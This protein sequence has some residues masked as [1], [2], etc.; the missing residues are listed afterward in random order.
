MPGAMESFPAVAT[1]HNHK[2]QAA[3]V[4][5][6][7]AAA[8]IMASLEK[9]YIFS[10]SGSQGQVL[11]CCSVNIE[12]FVST[13]PYPESNLTRI[14]PFSRIYNSFSCTRNCN[15]STSLTVCSVHKS[16]LTKAAKGTICS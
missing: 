10:Y 14:T 9:D 15:A 5:A 8:R 12:L 3:M 7:V 2:V 4:A 1:S 13:G 6:A 16:Q 11:H